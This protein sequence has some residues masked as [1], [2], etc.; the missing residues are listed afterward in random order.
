MHRSS[1]DFTHS[2][3]NLFQSRDS[4]DCCDLRWSW[5]RRQ[6]QYSNECRWESVVWRVCRSS[7]L[8]GAFITIC[9]PSSLPLINFYGFPFLDQVLIMFHIGQQI[10][11]ITKDDCLESLVFCYISGCPFLNWFFSKKIWSEWS[12][13]SVSVNYGIGLS[14]TVRLI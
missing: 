5:T 1:S 10:L 4:Q 11:Q 13:W 9:S 14:L 12:I 2:G 7:W 8:A 3:Q 6:S